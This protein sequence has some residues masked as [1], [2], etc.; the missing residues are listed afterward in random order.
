MQIF[1]AIKEFAGHKA[2][3]VKGNTVKTYQHYLRQFALYLHNSDLEKLTLRDLD[4]YLNQ[5]RELGY[6]QNTFTPITIALRKF[7]EFTHQRRWTELDSD[8]LEVPDKEFNMPRVL[9]EED[10][11]KLI[12]AAPEDRAP[13]RVLRNRLIMR[14]LWD[15]GARV[16][17]ICSLNREDIR[18][19]EA[20]IR[21]EKN[22]GSRP[23]RHIFWGEETDAAMQEWI[24]V[25][26]KYEGGALFVSLG[27]AKIGERLTIKGVGEMLRRYSQYAGLPR[28]VNAHSFRHAKAHAILKQGGSLADAANVLG[29]ASYLSSRPYTFMWGE[30]LRETAG[31]FLNT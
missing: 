9:A 28:V 5:L 10:Y 1:E 6:Q 14:L 30:E 8:Y 29:H 16:G 25:S 17:E 18:G 2:Y 12:A 23:L 27:N 21:T 19:R 22:R 4:D 7:L 11:L 24:K 20:Q 13:A 26:E 3:A 31:K 15:T